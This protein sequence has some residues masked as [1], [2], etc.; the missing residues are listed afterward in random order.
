MA[1]T[2]S[3]INTE[4]LLS[5]ILNSFEPITLDEMGKVKLMNRIDTKYVVSVSQLMSILRCMKDNYRVQIVEQHKIATYRTI[6]LDTDNATMYLMHQNGQ[7][8]REKIRVRTYVDSSLTFLEVKN[9]NNHGRTK[10]TRIRV[11]SAETLAQDG[12]EAFLASN[13]WYK[14]QELSPRLENHFDRITLVDKDMTERLTIDLG[15]SFKNHKNG[16]ETSLPQIAVVELKREGQKPSFALDVLKNH[17]IQR[18]SFSK[19]CMGCALTDT[20]LKQ[21][22]FKPKIRAVQKIIAL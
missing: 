2:S 15:I 20:T 3:S 5:S 13:A 14:L 4:A 11:N 21:N 10:K 17:R 1:S 8:T 12:A 6:Y 22:R 19:Y 7:K 18:A 16:R 9:K